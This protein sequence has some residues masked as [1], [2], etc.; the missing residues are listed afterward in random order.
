[1]P[2]DSEVR[3]LALSCLLL[4]FVGPTPPGWLLDA[5]GAGLG[6]VVLFGSNVGDGAGQVRELTDRLRSAAGRDVAVIQCFEQ[7]GDACWFVL[8]VAIHR[9]QH[10]E[11]A[12]QKTGKC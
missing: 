9:H 12:L 6:G 1:M 4:G 10:V 5:L 7:D 3:R 2:D 8:T 11:I